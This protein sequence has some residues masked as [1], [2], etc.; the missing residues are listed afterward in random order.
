[1]GKVKI[2]NVDFAEQSLSLC[3]LYTAKPIS[4]P[5][6]VG[7]E[8]AVFIAGSLQTTKGRLM[9][10]RPSLPD[11]SQERVL[12]DTKQKSEGCRV[13]DQL[14]DFRLAGGDVTG[15]FGESWWQPPSS[16][17]SWWGC[18][19]HP[20]R[21]WGLASCRTAQRSVLDCGVYPFRRS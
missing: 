19:H 3:T 8:S 17:F 12:K 10:K 6:M 1:M 11:D 14:V 20:H 4:W 5:G 13:C 7:K 9:F 18:S 15:W 2:I 21:G 16:S